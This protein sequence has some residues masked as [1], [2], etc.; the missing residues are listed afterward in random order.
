MFPRLR[1]GNKVRDVRF[2]LGC[3]VRD[4]VANGRMRGGLEGGETNL[5]GRRCLGVGC[6]VVRAESAWVVMGFFMG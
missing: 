4:N 6:C 2:G 3:G 5:G 1:G